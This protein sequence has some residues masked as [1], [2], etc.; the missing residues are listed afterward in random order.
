MRY[1][2]NNNVTLLLIMALVGVL[3]TTI[4]FAAFSSTLTI[5]GE[6]NVTPISSTFGVKFSSNSTKL[7][8]N[9]IT[10]TGNG[11]A[12]IINNDGNPTIKNLNASFTSPG[13]KVVYKFYVLNTGEYDAYLSSVVYNNAPNSST[14]KY[15]DI[16]TGTDTSLAN[17]ACSSI[18]VTTQID[19][20]SYTDTT[21]NITGHVLKKGASEV[22]TVTI[23]YPS[24]SSMADGPFSIRFGNIYLTYGSTSLSGTPTLPEEEPICKAVL[25]SDMGNVPS[26]SYAA[27]DEYTCQVN[28][29]TTHNFYILNTDG[30]KVNLIMDRNICNDGTEATASNLCTVFWVI[31]DDYLAAGGDEDRWGKYSCTKGPITA[32]KYLA[33]A[34]S[35]WS[36]IPSL[37]ETYT[38]ENTSQDWNYGTISLT[39]KARMIKSSEIKTFKEAKYLFNYLRNNPSANFSNTIDGIYGYWSL[40]SVNWYGKTL[41]H[42]GGPNYSVVN[43]N[44]YGDYGVRPVITLLKSDLG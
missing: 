42:M 7:E 11:S 3:G 35:S 25:T 37:N 33:E 16:P 26:G 12:A 4:A 21:L 17:S 28:D 18:K 15:C 31:K 43:E 29:T 20:L 41:Y 1:R 40:S 30:D 38:D 34:T 44:G 6:A 9:N 19:T 39:G 5:K 8:T 13:E 36:N 22:V 10:P 2:R 24:G 32:L 23:E 27:G 14:F